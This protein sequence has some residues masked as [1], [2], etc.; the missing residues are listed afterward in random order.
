MMPNDVSIAELLKVQGKDTLI[1]WL[2]QI[3]LEACYVKL[4]GGQMV[5]SN[6]ATVE[7]TAYYFNRKCFPK[8]M[9]KCFFA[10]HS[11][12]FPYV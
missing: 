1:T 6:D 9:L 2:Q 10:N 11:K 5:T 12:V 4:N 7:P 8:N 3:L